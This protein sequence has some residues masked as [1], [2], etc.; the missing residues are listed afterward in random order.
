[1][2]KMKVNKSYIQKNEKYAKLR[3]VKHIYI[4]YD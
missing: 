3:I 1:M 2:Y 4:L